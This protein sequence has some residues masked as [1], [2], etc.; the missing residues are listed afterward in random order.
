[1]LALGL[2]AGSVLLATRNAQALARLAQAQAGRTSLAFLLSAVESAET[3]Q[4]GF[5]LTGKESYLAP[6]ESGI[7][8][9]P[10]ALA[11]LTLELDAENDLGDNEPLLARLRRLTADKLEELG[12]TIERVRRGDRDGALDLVLSDRGQRDILGIRRTIAT[13]DD[14]QGVVLAQQIAL[15]N[16]SGRLLIWADTLGFVLLA[17]LAGAVAWGARQAFRALRLARAELSQA[18]AAL[19]VV[20]ETLEHRVARRTAALTAANDEIQRFAYIVS[21]DLR[22]PL[23]NIMG[24]T[25]E[26]ES[27]ATTLSRFV[28]R[29]A[30]ADPRAAQDALLATTED[31]PEAIGFI[32]TSTAKMDRLIGAILKL[33]REGRRVL[34]PEPVAMGPFFEGLAATLRHQADARGAVVS[35]GAVPDLVTDRVVLEQVFGNLLENALK[36]LQPGRPGRIEVGGRLEGDTA[37]IEVADNGRGIAERDHERVFELFRRA[38]DQTVPGEGIGLAH[39]RALVRRLG[40]R[41]DCVSAEGVGSTFRV[42]MPR[43][44]VATAP[45]R[46]LDPA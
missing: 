23:V 18:N 41:I 44:L 30:A 33:S 45:D 36:Y 2:I 29:A 34:T 19:S 43:T 1:M 11:R 17:A 12:I 22:A 6:Y 28:D 20:N 14:R 15:V 7:R 37:V 16:R 35:L 24:F 25:G 13:L 42:A 40:G 10:A 4:R 5:L 21:H 38:G 8:D 26:L 3:G 46:E 9:T 39:V 32:K 31:I 27:A